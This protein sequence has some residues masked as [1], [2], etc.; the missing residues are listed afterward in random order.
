MLV[1]GLS[2]NQLI[3]H[4]PQTM[5]KLFNLSYFDIKNNLLNGVLP[6]FAHI[7]RL[8]YL[9]IDLHLFVGIDVEN[10]EKLSWKKYREM[11]Y[12]NWL[13][14]KSFIMFLYCYGL[15]DT[16]TNIKNKYQNVNMKMNQL[17][18]S[19]Q[20]YHNNHNTTNV[21]KVFNN[22]YMCRYISDFL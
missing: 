19:D 1:L 14:V 20:V 11:R 13:R 9:W 18:L 8:Q 15:I 12:N 22:T 21:E 17:L 6:R 2:N 3:G 7:S 16:S 4:L 5:S 10:I